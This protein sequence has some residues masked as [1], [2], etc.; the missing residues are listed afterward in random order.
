MRETVLFTVGNGAQSLTSWLLSYL[1]TQCVHHSW[2]L[3]STVGRVPN[4]KY[5]GIKGINR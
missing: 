3:P 4:N 5:V 2:W 1:L